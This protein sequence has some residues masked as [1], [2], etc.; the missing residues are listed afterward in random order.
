[1]IRII[2]YNCGLQLLSSLPKKSIQHPSIVS[3][4]KKRKK[5]S[6]LVLL[7]YSLHQEA[8]PDFLKEN[9]GR[10]EIVHHCLVNYL[11]SVIFSVWQ[12]NIALVIHTIEN[13]YFN[14]LNMWNP[15]LSFNRFRGLMEHLLTNF[16]VICYFR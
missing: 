2:L 13:K 3:D 1:M 15:P 12:N 5:T 7:D 9:I 16:I 8:I 14:V 6:G 11:Y 4:L 10:P